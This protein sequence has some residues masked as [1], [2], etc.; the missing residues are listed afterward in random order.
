MTTGR[1][2]ALPPL[3]STRRLTG[4]RST[5]ARTW[6]RTITSRTRISREK[7]QPP[8]EMRVGIPASESYGS[9]YTYGIAENIFQNNLY[10]SVTD[11]NGVYSY[12]WSTQEEI[13]QSTVTGWMNSAGTGKISSHPL[14]TARGSGLLSLLTTRCTS[15][16]TSADHGYRAGNCSPATSSKSTPAYLLPDHASRTHPHLP[17]W[18]NP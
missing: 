2:T 4:L 14:M 5:T 6:R 16:R 3:R 15:P 11:T 18:E 1:Q 9:Y 8:G 13:A 12:A 10:T 7:T 17:G